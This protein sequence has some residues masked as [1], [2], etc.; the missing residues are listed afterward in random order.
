MTQF[1]IS[2]SSED[3][4]AAELI[5]EKLQN[6]PITVWQDRSGGINVGDQWRDKIES[7]IRGSD[8]ILIVDHQ[9]L[10]TFANQQ[11]ENIFGYRIGEILGQPHDMLLP[12]R[13]RGIHARHQATYRDKPDARHMAEGRDIYGVHKNGT[14]FQVEVGLSP[15]NAETNPQV[16]SIV[17]DI[18]ERKRSEEA[19]RKSEEKYRTLL[20]NLD[21]GVVVH[22]AD[23]RILLANYRAQELLGLTEDEML[24]RKDIDPAWHFLRKD[25]TRLPKEEY[26]VN[27]VIST[28]KPLT[29]Y[30]GGINNPK[31]K[32]IVWVIVNA[33]A[34][35][36]KNN[37]LKQIVVT[38]WDYTQLKLAKA[39]LAKRTHDLAKANTELQ[40]QIAERKVVEAE[41]KKKQQQFAKDLEV[42]AG[43]QQSLIPS[44][45]PRVESIRVAWRFEPC[46]QIGGDTFNFQYT[47]RNHISFYMLDVCGH[48]VSSALIS[49]MVSQ[50]L[51]TN[52]ELSDNA[53]EAVRPEAVLNSLERVFPFERYDSFFTIVYVTVDYVNGS[54][55]YSCAGHP[56]PVLLHADGAL[57]VLDV[58]GPVI[59]AGDGRPFPQAEK[60]L[61]PGDKIVLYTDGVL[62]YSN[63]AGEFFGKQRFYAALQKHGR[64]P[65]QM[66]MDSVQTAIKDFAG[67]ARS[68]DDL[69]MMVVEYV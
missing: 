64:L 68:A 15:Y 16:I 38:F 9:G 37:F 22:A 51:Q 52:Y 47:S 21:T 8:A 48:G 3:G 30:I 1:F 66:L 14:K 18:S 44:Y 25:G 10:I 50:F 20:S 33:F 19:L 34:E 43:I 55:R 35:Y 67:S 23:T 28:G 5:K 17:R 7:G 40:L 49:A 26:P 60:Q 31:S 61:H 46:E 42:A 41:L 62:D 13:F 57:E 29:N 58:H 4:D 56:S 53:S 54:L 65:V 69:S 24:G 6:Y 11:V 39:A 2:Y 27:V 59:G 32:E 63:L 36:D 45:S 12:E